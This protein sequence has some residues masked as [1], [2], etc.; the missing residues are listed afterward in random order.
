MAEELAEAFAEEG[1]QLLEVLEQLL[2]ALRLP[3]PGDGRE[4]LAAGVKRR[5]HT[6]KG[7]A[8]IIGAESLQ[9]RIHRL[10]DVAVLLGEDP[11]AAARLEAALVPLREV[12]VA[13]RSTGSEAAADGALVALSALLEK[14]A[15]SSGVGAALSGERELRVPQ[16]RLDELVARV[17][18]AAAGQAQ[19]MRQLAELPGN[20]GSAVA[21]TAEQLGTT[22]RA[23]Q[24]SV[25]GVRNLRVGALFHRFHRLVREEASAHGKRVRL[26]VSGASVEVDKAVLD[27]LSGP[28]GHLVR[29]AVVHGLEV[30][31]ARLA[32]GKRREGVVSLCAEA[33]G[34]RVVVRVEDDGRGL[35]RG[36]VRRKA[37]ALGLPLDL[38]AEE[39]IFAPGLSTAA[40]SASA[41]RGVGLDAV[42]RTVMEV[43]GRVTVEARSGGGTRF[44]LQLPVSLALQPAVL[45]ELGTEAYAVPAAAVVE[46]VALEPR[47]VRFTGAGHALEHRGALLPLVDPSSALGTGT[48][49]GAYALVLEAQGRAALPVDAVHGQRALA[50]QPLEA[51]LCPDS[52]ASAAALAWDGSVLLRLDPSALVRAARGLGGYARRQP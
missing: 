41:G 46:L 10:E 6:L 4:S 2:V 50:F 37:E 8:G 27:A 17:G 3:L 18:E 5:L 48:S 1:L 38:P 25:L 42:R 15:G 47:R 19:L 29:N 31:A 26:E 34:D 44:E 21:A 16:A 22:L 49:R 33:L 45:V 43:G 14:T 24:G 36:A 30:P 52:P 39:L 9:E 11:E 20:R 13:V 35:D 7:N 12:L 40:L 51:G 28:L 23:L 32:A